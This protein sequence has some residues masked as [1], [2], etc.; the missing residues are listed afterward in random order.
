MNKEQYALYLQSPH[1]RE[2]R[3]VKLRMS[4]FSC[5]ACGFTH[6][7]QV[8]HLTYRNLSKE[9]PGDLMVLCDRCHKLSH[10][11]CKTPPSNIPTKWSR[12][13]L[14]HFLTY[15]REASNPRKQEKVGR[16][17]ANKA[18]NR[19][20]QRAKSMLALAKKSFRERRV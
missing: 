6:K 5:D 9:R 1:W 15:C 8:H 7:L 2:T 19:L 16:S 18:L 14:R 3:L 13:M 10:D 17:K 11:L 20:P 12:I 4:G